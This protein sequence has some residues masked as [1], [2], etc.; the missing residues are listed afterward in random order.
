MKFGSAVKLE[1]SAYTPGDIIDIVHEFHYISLNEE[2]SGSLPRM[3]FLKNNEDNQPMIS[4][5][6]RMLLDA[7]KSREPSMSLSYFM[8]DDGGILIEL[9]RDDCVEI[10]YNRRVIHLILTQLNL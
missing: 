9:A 3:N 4:D 7:I 2:K 1:I 6:N 10:I 8:E 5:L